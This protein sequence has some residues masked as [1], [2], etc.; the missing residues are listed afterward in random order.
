MRSVLA[1]LSVLAVAGAAC[2]KTVDTAGFENTLKDKVIEMGIAD[3][4]VTCPKGVEAKPGNAFTCKIAVGDKA[5]DLKVTI[6]KVDGKRVDMTTEFADGNAFP[7]AK[8]EGLL[9][10]S[11]Q[12]KFAD[13][14]IDCGAEPLLFAKDDKIYCGVTAGD[15]TGKLRV[16]VDGLDLKGWQIE[17]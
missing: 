12:Q 9:T 10:E 6:D 1:V 11:V 7:R 15:H 14:K 17:E 8:L 13:A 16:D 4:S 5:Y 2:K 3:P